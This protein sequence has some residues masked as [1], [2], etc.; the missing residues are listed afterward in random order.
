MPD[1]TAGW[2]GKRS[3]VPAPSRRDRPAAE[4]PALYLRPT[5]PFQSP[6][7]SS[8]REPLLSTFGE[9]DE[10]HDHG[11]ARVTTLVNVLSVEPENQTKLIESLCQNADNVVSTLTGWISTS[12][13]LSHDKRR[14]V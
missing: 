12:L 10:R 5:N 1:N 9:D 13:V 4:P 3:R 14:V 8:T 2:H 11:Y 7:S 6:A